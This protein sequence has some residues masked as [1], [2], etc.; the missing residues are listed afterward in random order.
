MLTRFHNYLCSLRGYSPRTAAGYIKDIQ[1]FLT[2]MQAY[3]LHADI[4]RVT[5]DDLDDYVTFR[6]SE[7]I[8]PATTNRELASIS[9][10]YRYLRREG[11]ISEN[12]AQYESRR[13]VAIKQPN[14]IPPEDLKEAY[15]HAS[16]LSRLLLGLLITTGL[17]T[18]EIMAMR[19][20]D[21]DFK[22]CSIRLHGKGNKE[23]EVF[24]TAEVLSPLADMARE[25]MV[26]GLVFHIPE[27]R[28]R[29]L[30]FWALQPYTDAKQLSP[31]AI[32]HTFATEC[33]RQ[34][35]NTSTLAQMLGHNRIETTQHYIDLAQSRTQEAFKALNILT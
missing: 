28:V 4:Y 27:R 34:G 30:V 8:A 31:H 29:R 17:R 11:Q 22:A 23:R 32:R 14:T 3:K 2:W 16:G 33:A 12:P 6:C 35:V 5:R 13:K 15:N 25:R 20:E 1:A 24:T 19:W 9:A 10:L 7:G 26:S 21:I 18:C